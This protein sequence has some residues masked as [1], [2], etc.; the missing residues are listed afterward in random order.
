MVEFLSSVCTLEPGDVIF[1][2]ALNHLPPLKAGDKMEHEIEGLG[3]FTTV[4]QAEA[5]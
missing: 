1:S 5:A 4:C 3:K 2:G